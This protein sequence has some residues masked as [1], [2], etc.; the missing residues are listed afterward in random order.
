ME[1]VIFAGTQ[2]RKP[3]GFAYVAITINNEDHKLK[4]PYEEV[5]IARRVYDPVKASTCSTVLRVV[6]GIFRNYC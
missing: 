3:Q 6:C 1:D 4:V 2:L 5:K